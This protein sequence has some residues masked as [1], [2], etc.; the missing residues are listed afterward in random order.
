MF[1]T[2]SAL[3]GVAV[4]ATAGLAQEKAPRVDYLRDVRPILSQHCYH[5]HGPD[6]G[7]RK[8]ELRLD[9]K[10]SALAEREGEFVITPGDPASSMLVAHVKA[11]LGYDLMPPAR[12]DKPLSTEQIATLES[13]IAQGA[14]WPE[15]WAFQAPVRPA[16]PEAGEGW[17]ANAL[18]RFVHRR[19]SAE[20]LEPAPEASREALI[21]RLTFDLTGLPPTVDEIDAF[22]KDESPE[23]YEKLVDRLLASPAFGERQAQ[24]WLDVARYADTNGYQSDGERSAWKWREWVI[25]AFNRN[26][27]FDQFTVEQLAG[28]LLPDATLDQKIATGFN[29]NHAT[30]SEAG[31]EPDEYRTNYVI[32]RLDTTATAFL[33]LTLACAQCHDHKFDPL[34]QKDF[35]RFYGYFNQ[36]KERD[37]RFSFAGTGR[38]SAPSMRVPN[39][40]QAPHESLL[41][42]RIEELKERLKNDDLYSDAAQQGWEKSILESVGEDV[43]WK[44]LEPIGMMAENGSILRLQD[45]GSILATGEAPVR[46]VYELAFKP[47]RGKI[48]ALKI[49]AIPDPSQPEGASGRGRHGRFILSGLKIRLSSLSESA[50]PPLMWLAR[51]E[52]DLSQ[53]RPENAT[54]DAITPGGIE[55]AIIISD[56]E[57]SGP[58]SFGRDFRVRGWSIAGDER[59]R[60]H[61]AILVPLETLAINEASVLRVTIEQKSRPFKSLLGR[62]RISYTE[63]ERVRA[64]LLPAVTKEWSAVGPFPAEDAAAAHKSDFEPEK[65]L[66]EGM[67]LRAEYEKPVVAKKTDPKAKGASGKSGSAASG[68]GGKPG[69]APATGKKPGAPAPKKP[70]AAQPEPAKTPTAAASQPKTPKT[71]GKTGAEGEKKPGG[72]P[73]VAGKDKT[74]ALPEGGKPAAGES[75]PS[76]S[77]PSAGKGATKP[78]KPAKPLAA[79]PEEAPKPSARP[80]RPPPKLAWKQQ[81]DWR[82]GRE[83]R[84]EDGNVAWYLTRKIHS[85]KARTVVMNFDGP[86]GV[87]A[88]LNGEL[89]F[90]AAPKPKEAAASRGSSSGFSR[91]RRPSRDE[92]REIR[93]GLR[94]GESELV[95]KVVF[96]ASPTSSRGRRGST[97]TANAEG[98]EAMVPPEAAAAMAARSRDDQ[99]RGRFNFDFEAQGP[100]VVSYEVIRALRELA[101]APV[102]RTVSKPSGDEI[103]AEEARRGELRT[104]IRK[105]YR[106][107]HDTVGQ[108][109]KAEIAELESEKRGLARRMPETPVMEDLEPDKMRETHVFIRGDFRHKGEKVEPGVPGILHPL[110]E[111]LPKNRLGLARWIVDPRNPLLARVTVN[112]LWQQYF[113]KGLVATPND[114][115]K[116]SET[117]SHPELLDWLAVEFVESGWDLKKLHKLVVMSA[118]YRQDAK[119]DPAKLERDPDNR[120]LARGPRQRMSAEMIRDN[121]L[122]ASG[123]LV[124]KL[125]GPSVRPYQP[126][127]VSNA[128]ARGRRYRKDSGEDQ[129]RRGLYVFWSRGTPY[130]SMITFDAAK[131][132]ICSVQEARTTTPLQ[133]LVLLNDPVYVEAARKLGER[134]L[135]SEGG[136]DDAARIARGFRLCTG[137][138][139]TAKE[140]GILAGLLAEQRRHFKA[141]PDAAKKLLA[142][143][144]SKVK[145]GLEPAEVA[146]W[147]TV[148]ATILN[149]DAAIHK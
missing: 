49:E 56:D 66:K 60:E 38:N 135:G 8:A 36:V 138:A 119:I 48:A 83:I 122:A 33:G 129:Y 92:E 132:E 19:L 89:I 144:D 88:W 142:V 11:E 74:P 118:T 75:A 96:A 137:R 141:A 105:H 100:D 51:A 32:D 55:G 59:F 7:T 63:D 145:E 69:G 106:E 112:R 62:F 85:T 1:R 40:D 15:H 54:I 79:A 113:G 134:L 26:M 128:V 14:D 103:D 102:A 24:E 80:R 3:L 21:R 31:D 86:D 30:N 110:D 82:D 18:D 41:D 148:A 22:V 139:P 45:D 121:A 72:K 9:Q 2:L 133:A 81:R 146:A 140:T 35:Y 114:F 76:P 27:P 68:A 43:A 67:D 17:A 53:E 65:R 44:T 95:V 50:D 149:L 23:A 57:K 147:T 39:P 10:R 125:G 34:S 46:D 58:Q 84:L 12:F 78:E 109:I 13:W 117:P 52:A 116:R 130:P 101:D 90:E 104:R 99:P 77:A 6:G 37:N 25:E 70:E 61:E 5:C 91:F 123:L 108:I 94:E 120:L 143:G 73:P 124:A 71:P 28:D 42:A 20:Q 29:R 97:P 47:G 107:N 136:Q 93:V 115:G 126:T 87:K 127:A 16:L 4:L 64:P 111:K 131:R 98:A